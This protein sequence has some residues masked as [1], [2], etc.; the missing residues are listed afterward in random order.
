MTECIQFSTLKLCVR[1]K[2]D[3]YSGTNKLSI[4]RKTFEVI[5]T[6]LYDK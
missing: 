2:M 4:I 1:I 5:C 3:F 6:L